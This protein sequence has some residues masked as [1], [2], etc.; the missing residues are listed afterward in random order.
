MNSMN[1]YS[2]YILLNHGKAKGFVTIFLNVLF[3]L[4]NRFLVFLFRYKFKVNTLILLFFDFGSGEVLLIV[5]AIFLVFGPEKIPGMARNL[6]KFI[7]EMKRATED[8]KT[9]IN[10]E[11]NRKERDKKL[12]EYKVRMKDQETT[13]NNGEMPEEKKREDKTKEKNQIVDKIQEPESSVP[14]G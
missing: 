8:I 7:N 14:K 11:A 5:L 3:P 6:G 4:I 12:E 2:T 10:R 9:E 1:L 13:Q